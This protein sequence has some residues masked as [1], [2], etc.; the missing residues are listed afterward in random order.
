MSPSGSNFGHKHFATHDVVALNSSSLLTG[1]FKVIYYA[2][3]VH[4][5]TMDRWPKQCGC[6]SQEYH[7][8]VFTGGDSTLMLEQ[9]GLLENMARD[10]WNFTVF[11]S[12]GQGP[13]SLLFHQTES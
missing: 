11:Q 8:G 5:P 13:A 9:V 10:E 4:F 6:Q 2:C 12:L 3:K 7:G 1:I